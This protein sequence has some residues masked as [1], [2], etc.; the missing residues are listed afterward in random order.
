M[1]SLLNK[2]ELSYERKSLFRKKFIFNKCDMTSHEAFMDKG[3]LLKKLETYKTFEKEWVVY[4]YRK[5][6]SLNQHYKEKFKWS[7][8]ISKNLCKNFKKFIKERDQLIT[9]YDFASKKSRSDGAIRA[10]RWKGIDTTSTN[11]GRFEI[12]REQ[13]RNKQ[14]P[15]FQLVDEFQKWMN[16]AYGNF[17]TKRVDGYDLQRG[18]DEIVANTQQFIALM[19]FT[20]IKFYNLA[21]KDN[22]NNRDILLEI[23]TGM[24][25]RGDLHK[26]IYQSIAF[27]LKEEISTLESRMTK[28]EN[29]DFDK[30]RYTEGISDV[31]SFSSSKRR[32]QILR[33]KS[34]IPEMFHLDTETQL[35]EDKQNSRYERCSQMI[36]MIK[37]VENPTSKIQKLVNVTN[38]IKEEIDE[39]WKGIPM[40][41]D[42]KRIDADNMERLMGYII[43]KSKY[44]KIVVDLAII[45]YFS[46]NHIDFGE[47]GFIYVCIT[48]SL[49]QIVNEKFVTE[50][51][52]FDR[53]TPRFKDSQRKTSQFKRISDE[54]RGEPNQFSTSEVKSSS[55]DVEEIPQVPFYVTDV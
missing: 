9:A 11:M 44:S 29:V 30:S 5:L 8:T 27:C 52:K 55:N 40:D 4:L 36:S 16:K 19:F 47:N 13:M 31:F 1:I 6:N 46:G 18:R 24:V 51:D 41:Q 42:D 17:R 21:F 38:L 34:E 33:K 53:R 10:T 35:L 32:D 25:V 23:L 15:I 3:K 54:K 22:E 28:E 20:T 26:V 12:L 7:Y 14:H 37:S 48:N 45:D 50:E 43:V 2:N 49:Q 39:F